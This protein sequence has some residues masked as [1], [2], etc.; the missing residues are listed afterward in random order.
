[1]FIQLAKPHQ[2]F[3]FLESVESRVYQESVAYRESIASLVEHIAMLSKADIERSFL[4]CNFTARQEREITAYL[5]NAK[6]DLLIV[7]EFWN[8]KPV[9]A[10]GLAMKLNWEG[11]NHQYKINEIRREAI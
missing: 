6:A 11:S 5:S 8:R 10:I 1:M 7:R 2:A 3:A 4:S 9:K